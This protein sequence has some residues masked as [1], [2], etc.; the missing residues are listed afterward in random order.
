M[1]LIEVSRGSREERGP[2]GG[3][4]WPIELASGVWKPAS[5]DQSEEESQCQ[6]GTEVEKGPGL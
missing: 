4:M 5:V 6:N 2:Y 1:W 3:M